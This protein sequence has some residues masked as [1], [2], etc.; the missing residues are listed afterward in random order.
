MIM[1]HPSRIQRPPQVVTISTCVS[2]PGGSCGEGQS[3]LLLDAFVAPL[4]NRLGVEARVVFV[5]FVHDLLLVRGS[6]P[7]KAVGGQWRIG[8][9][10]P[11]IND[12]GQVDGAAP[13]AHARSHPEVEPD[14]RLGKEGVFGR[15]GT[16]S[17]PGKFVDGAA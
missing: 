14:K 4:L 7:E 5:L 2:V 9:L 3:R 6:E 1:N 17:Q 10:Q 13:R 15:P 16:K 8:S 11:T 12:R